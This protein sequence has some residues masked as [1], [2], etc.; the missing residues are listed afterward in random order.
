MPPLPPARE[1]ICWAAFV[2]DTVTLAECGQD[3]HGG[4]VLTLAKKIL[5]KKPS[6]GWEYAWL[7]RLRACKFHLHEKSVVWSACCVYA[8]EFSE[9][10]AK[11]FLEK[12]LFLTEPLRE[13]PLWRQG[14]NL[15]AHASFAPTMLQRMEQANSTGKLALVTQQM[16]EVKGMMHENIEVRPAPGAPRVP[17]D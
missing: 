14:G 5:G 10:Q 6:P 13:S 2:R 3:H 16:D 17:T 11:G 8:S 7:G 15:A 9:L 1:G 12:L 4:A